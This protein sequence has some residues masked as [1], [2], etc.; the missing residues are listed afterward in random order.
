MPKTKFQSVVFTLIMVFCMV[1]CMTVFTV[2]DKLGGLSGSVFAAA[3]KEMWIEYAIVFLLVFFVVTRLAVKFA[4]R[5]FSPGEVK[6]IFNI[7]AVQC[8]TVCM[9]VPAITLIAVFLHNGFTADW[10]C[11]WLTLAAKC[12][13]AALCLQLFFVGPFVRFIFRLIFSGG[14]P[15]GSAAETHAKNGNIT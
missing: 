14:T 15:R 2:A 12:F 8:F 1:F 10:F 3:I 11:E 4:G 5:L 6:P 9:V 7:L 13:P